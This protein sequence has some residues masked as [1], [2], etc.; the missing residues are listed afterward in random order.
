LIAQ[1]CVSVIESLNLKTTGTPHVFFDY[2]AA[3]ACLLYVIVWKS[4]EVRNEMS[5]FARDEKS[6][7]IST[8]MNILMNNTLDHLAVSASKLSSAVNITRELAILKAFCWYALCIWSLNDHG[9][10]LFQYNYPKCRLPIVDVSDIDIPTPVAVLNATLCHPQDI[11][12][13]NQLC[14]YL[15]NKQRFFDT[16]LHIDDGFLKL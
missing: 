6:V 11:K 4:K 2:G 1:F 12:M 9:L 7:N 16:G 10:A 3:I 15:S 8:I 14:K 5:I 13:P